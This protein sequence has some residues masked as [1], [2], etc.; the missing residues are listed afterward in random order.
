MTLRS[1]E[2]KIAGTLLMQFCLFLITFGVRHL[3]EWTKVTVR[4]SG[5]YWWS[6]PVFVAQAVLGAAISLEIEM[7]FYSK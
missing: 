1:P 5:A 2:I 7:W 3:G 6:F 4:F